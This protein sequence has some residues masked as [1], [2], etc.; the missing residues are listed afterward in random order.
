MERSSG[1]LR[2]RLNLWIGKLMTGFYHR[3]LGQNDLVTRG[4][5]GYLSEPE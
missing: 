5:S 4:V 3:A 1:D 2:R